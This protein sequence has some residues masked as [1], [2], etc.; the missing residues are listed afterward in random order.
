MDV[1]DWLK[2]ILVGIIASIGLALLVGY[3]LLRMIDA[4]EDRWP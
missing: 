4:D 2:L 3:F 1:I